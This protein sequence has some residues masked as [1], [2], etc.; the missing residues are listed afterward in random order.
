MNP[1]EE[2]ILKFQGAQKE[3]LAFLHQYFRDKGLRPQLSYGLPFYY[4][5]RWICYLKSNKD[6][7]LDLSFTRANQFE[8]PTGLLEDRDRR[9]IKSLVL[10]PDQDLPMDAI[11]QIVEA[12]I[13]LDGNKR[14]N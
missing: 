6:G 7:S 13:A 10:W 2:Y 12:A 14:V 11:E 8:D 4:G 5:N 1:A 9:Q 3:L